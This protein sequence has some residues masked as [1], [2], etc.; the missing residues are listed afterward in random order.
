MLFR[1]QPHTYTRTKALFDEFAQVLKGADL[2]VLTDI[3]AARETDDLGVSSTQLAQAVP[4]ALYF[5]SLDDLETGL[6]ALTRP[7]DL[8]LLVGAGDIYSV[9]KRLAN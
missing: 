3:Y 8:I 4:G 5:P 6:R 7:G 9:G 1:S 2:A